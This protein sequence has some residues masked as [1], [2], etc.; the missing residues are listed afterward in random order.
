MYVLRSPYNIKSLS[1]PIECKKLFLFDYDFEFQIWEIRNFQFLSVS[2][3][4]WSVQQKPAHLKRLCEKYLCWIW[5][6]VK[7]RVFGLT[8]PMFIRNFGNSEDKPIQYSENNGCLHNICIFLQ[9]SLVPKM[10]HAKKCHLVGMDM[11][12]A[13]FFPQ[14]QRM[15]CHSLQNTHLDRIK[16]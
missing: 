2:Q 12:K 13:T 5:C 8:F 11:I 14:S 4:G 3:S 7:M 6:A 10:D 15:Q 16:M 9:M 1:W